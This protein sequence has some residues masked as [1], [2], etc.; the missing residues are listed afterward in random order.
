M[1]Q[2]PSLR[3]KLCPFPLPDTIPGSALSFDLLGRNLPEG[4][5]SGIFGS[6]QSPLHQANRMNMAEVSIGMAVVDGRH[7]R[8]I[9][10]DPQL[11][12]PDGETR[13]ILEIQIFVGVFFLRVEV[14]HHFAGVTYER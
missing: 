6:G 2:Y 13:D 9:S 12:L 1:I 4:L 5:E 14:D 7:K 11:H 10:A 8:H 3:E